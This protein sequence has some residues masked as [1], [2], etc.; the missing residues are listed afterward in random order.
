MSLG[1]GLSV[2]SDGDFWAA[3]VDGLGQR[4]QEALWVAGDQGQ[5]DV[6][7]VFACGVVYDGKA[8][9]SG[10]LGGCG[11]LG[12]RAGCR[13]GGDEE[14]V[15]GFPNRHFGQEREAQQ[16]RAKT[17]VGEGE[18]A[19]A[20]R[21]VLVEELEVGVE[22]GA[23][24][25]VEQ[26]D[27]RVGREEQ[28]AGGAGVGDDGEEALLECGSCGVVGLW[29]LRRLIQLGGRADFEREDAAG[30]GGAG[31]GD[32]DAG[33][34]QGVVEVLL[35]GLFAE[36]EREGVELLGQGRGGVVVGAGDVTATE[37]YGGEGL[38]DVVQ[39]GRGEVE[40]DGLIAGDAAFV[41]EEAYPIFVERDVGDAEV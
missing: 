1:H 27:A 3:V 33:T 31:A 9:E 18:V 24:G 30:E 20:F 17:V 28:G 26:A 2:C 10:V 19:G 21:A 13:S 8:L 29:G 14:P 35:G 11:W 41:L 12:G 6:L 23:E 37:V 7:P 5:L 25:G 38:E 32:L 16:A 22:V 36:G 15:G 39:L 34:A 40:A 4:L